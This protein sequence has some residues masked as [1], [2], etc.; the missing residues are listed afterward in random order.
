MSRLI[1]D[2]VLYRLIHRCYLKKLLEVKEGM[3]TLKGKALKGNQACRCLWCWRL[4]LAQQL[5]IWE[6]WMH[7]AEDL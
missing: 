2:I 7:L 1:N 4:K 6:E 5:L 3:H